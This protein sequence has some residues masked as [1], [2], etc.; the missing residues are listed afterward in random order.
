MSSA[1]RR[2][3]DRSAEQPA[4]PPGAPFANT[5]DTD[6]TIP[7]N[8]AWA[9]RC[10][11]AAP[12]ATRMP[13]EVDDPS[14]IDDA[15]ARAAEAGRR[16]AARPLPARV[17]VLLR[18]AEVM[19]GQRGESI[20]IMVH[21]ASKTVTEA[22]VEVSEA[23][24]FARYYA[25]SAQRL[26]RLDSGALLPRGV[27]VVVPPWN[28]P[29]AIPAGGVLAALAAGN[30]VILKP[31]PQTVR[32]AWLLAA[33]AVDCGGAGRPVAVPPRRE[34]TTGRRLVTHPEVDA[35]VLTGSFDTAAMFLDWRP[36]LHLLAE[37]SG[38]NAIVV[39]AHADIDLAVA[40]LV[41]SAFGHAGQKCS[42]AS[43]AIVTAAGARRPPLPA[44]ARRRDAL[45]R[46]RS[47]GRARH[48]HGPADR[49][50]GRR[51][52]P[53]PDPARRR[54]ALA[55]PA[56][57]RDGDARRWT[58]GVRTG[59][60]QGAWFH[61]TECFGPVLGVMRADD[62]AHAIE[63]QNSV[64]FGLTGGLQSLDPGEIETWLAAV[65][66]G[67]AYVNRHITGAIVRRQPFGGW[68]RSAVGPTAKA[69]GPDYVG[70]LGRWSDRGEAPLEAVRDG[71]RAWWA[72]RHER[73]EDPSGLACERN[74][75]RYLPLPRPVLVRVDTSTD[76]QQLDRA[77]AAAAAVGVAVEV[78]SAEDDADQALAARIDGYSRLRLLAPADDVLRRAAHRA[79]VP[80]DDEPIA[81]EPTIELPRWLRAQ[82]ISQTLHR[83][84]N[85]RGGTRS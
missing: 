34:A 24:D 67:N 26:G 83:Y 12:D 28:F 66:V 5:P 49:A 2:R 68:K 23:I 56:G 32:T 15:V 61:R 53:G 36:D 65:Q 39:T 6:F 44:Q 25:D 13:D 80:V 3:Q 35:V 45:A 60:A 47:G 71:Y 10:L 41:H 22:D 4:F 38:K 81:A 30:A 16:W 82:A 64:D 14:E 79:N 50:A 70:A 57:R 58:P 46:G 11:D 59:V 37:T 21:E 33:P 31:A 76:P 7:V 63:L 54:R 84:G 69:G 72:V 75:L 77:L 73:G 74:E 78:S 9:Q 48:R 18:C 40:D 43:L 17:E 51:P 85:V 42:A 29:Y 55:R 52:A 8:R 27:V 19:A 20:A 62:L 1:P